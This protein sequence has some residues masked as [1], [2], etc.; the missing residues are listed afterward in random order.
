MNWLKH[1]ALALGAAAALGGAAL[2][3]ASAQVPRDRHA[4]YYYPPPVSIETY[5]ARAKVMAETNR[6]RR[7]G[8]VI[9]IIASMR[10]RPYPPLFDIFPKGTDAQKLIIVANQAGRLD[11]IYR[12]RALLAT[13]TSIARTMPI[14]VKYQV[15][16]FFTFLDLLKMLGFTQIT[17]SDGA[18]FAHQIKL[19]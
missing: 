18:A 5:T 8:F 13:L 10:Q 11:T 19:K 17:V 9:N 1:A 12:V 6:R 4:G 14:F 16:T 15:E 7:I 3:P 2:S